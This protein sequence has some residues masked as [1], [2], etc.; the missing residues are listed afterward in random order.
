M[1]ADTSQQREMAR[2][3]RPGVTID[4]YFIGW[5]IVIYLGVDETKPQLIN[6]V[7]L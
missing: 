3:H 5:E 1:R 7:K 6:S 2:V 4:L